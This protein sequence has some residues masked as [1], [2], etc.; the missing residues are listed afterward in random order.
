MQEYDLTD[1]SLFLEQE[2]EEKGMAEMRAEEQLDDLE[3]EL[4]VKMMLEMI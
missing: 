4:A 3:L 1:Y 2:T